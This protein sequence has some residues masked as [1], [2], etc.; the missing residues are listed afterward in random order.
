[1]RDKIGYAVRLVLVVAV[2]ASGFAYASEMAPWKLFNS[3]GGLAMGV[4]ANGTLQ[5]VSGQN[6]GSI[7]GS[8]ASSYTVT[9]TTAEPDTSYRVFLQASGTANATQTDLYVTTKN[10]TS[11]VV[12]PKIPTG[13]PATATID[14]F[15]IRN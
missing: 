15:K 1:M 11:F 10:T 8:L 9:F 4:D 14:W 3:S 12:T 2:I 5:F 13:I 6:N 7:T